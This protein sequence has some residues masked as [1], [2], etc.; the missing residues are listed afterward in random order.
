MYLVSFHH[1]FFCTLWVYCTVKPE[2]SWLWCVLFYPE[3][4]LVFERAGGLMT[5]R[6]MMTKV[7]VVFK[8]P[9]LVIFCLHLNQSLPPAD[10]LRET[11]MWSV[12][13]MALISHTAHKCEQTNG[14]VLICAGGMNLKQQ[15]SCG[16]PSGWL[17]FE[18]Y[19]IALHTVN[20]PNYTL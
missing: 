14:F 4:W 6:L 9:I 5:G 19:R 3:A 7:S 8:W 10:N 13:R 15:S 11:E 18:Y 12:L 17:I 1:C 16:E 20:Q 2:W